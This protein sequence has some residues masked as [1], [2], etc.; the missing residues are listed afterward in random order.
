MNY[1]HIFHAGNFADIFKHLVFRMV[2]DHVQ[3]KDKGA[4][5]LDAFAGIGAYDLSSSQA[6]RTLEYEDGIA[7]F[8]KSSF[9]NEDLRNFQDWV[10][11]DFGHGIYVGSPVLAARML[12][13]QDRLIANELH[14]E[15]VIELQQNLKSFRNAAVTR[16]D[17]YEVIRAQIPPKERRGVVL[18]DPPFEKKDEFNLLVRQMQEW[19]RRWATGCFI[20]WYPIKAS[21]ASQIDDLYLEAASLEMNRTWV[22]EFM[23]KD[24]SIPEGLNGCGLL[25]FNTP[26]KI[27]ER[28]GDFAAELTG[29]LGGN[30]RS[31]YL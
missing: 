7:A 17:A 21:A 30:I 2:M 23:I 9:R 6:Q 19:K 11:D 1:R 22:S 25:I 27:P 18:V 13:L 4:F 8:M 24:R 5:I 26:F 14:P 16:L 3:Q 29:A 31:F 12:R 10:Q 28:V 15:D 20:L